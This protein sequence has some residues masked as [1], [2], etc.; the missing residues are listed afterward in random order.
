M[1]AVVTFPRSKSNRLM[2]AAFEVTVDGAREQLTWL[3]GLDDEPSDCAA[4]N[5]PTDREWRAMPFE[6]RVVVLGKWLLAEAYEAADRGT[7][8]VEGVDPLHVVGTRD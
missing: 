1:T 8:L 3:L 2:S 4:H 6:Q 5:L 7:R